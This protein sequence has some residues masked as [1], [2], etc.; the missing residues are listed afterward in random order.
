MDSNTSLT[1]LR[2]TKGNFKTIDLSKNEQLSELYMNDANIENLNLGK[3][4]LSR[5]EINKVTGIKSLSVK[6]DSLKDLSLKIYGLESLDV[7][8]C[9]N[10]EELSIK[11]SMLEELDL[12]KNTLLQGLSIEGSLI[13]KITG[14]NNVSDE[15][16][17]SNSKISSLEALNSELSEIEISLSEIEELDLSNNIEL[18]YMYIVYTNLKNIKGIE[19]LSNIEELILPFNQIEKL[20]L[21][22][23]S[24]LKYVS[25]GFN[26]FTK[27]NVSM[28]AGT[29]IEYN[30]SLKLPVSI[31]KDTY[32]EDDTIA[33]LEDNKIKAIKEGETTITTFISSYDAVSEEIYDMPIRMYV[34]VFDI[35]SNKYIINK[36]HKYIYA[37]TQTNDNAIK[38]YVKVFGD[39][40]SKELINDK[41]KLLS[42][43]DVIETYD[44]IKISSSK[45]DLDGDVINYSGN[46]DLN[47][48]DVTNAE[49]VVI[50]DE[51]Q[52]VHDGI[53]VKTL[54]LNKGGK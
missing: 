32:N 48:I 47:K 20:D 28:I 43:S 4:N 50:E 1:S 26:P 14:L 53:I 22:K 10:L 39:D 23:L 35:Q 36:E 19:N 11:Q 38:R 34:K 49:L 12:T 3:N 33:V 21:S 54:K 40:V 7:T 37:G 42:G 16:E 41:F 30:P 9:P 44:V 6:S 8:E 5:I 31:D 15:L 18:E 13:K 45:Y 2:I 27:D 46:L 24:N 25:L 52:I 51:L 29:E 17:I